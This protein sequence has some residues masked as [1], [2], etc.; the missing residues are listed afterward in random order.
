MDEE[1]LGTLFNIPHTS[2]CPFTLKDPYEFDNLKI[3]D[4]LRIVKDCETTE[5]FF[6]PQ[7]VET[8]LINNVIHKLIRANLIT[9][10]G[11]RSDMTYQDLV[12]SSV[13][14]K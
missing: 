11:G 1:L 8:T 6:L 7:V 14:L 3:L 9:R 10:I 4:Q 5:I 13:I 12:L 2:V